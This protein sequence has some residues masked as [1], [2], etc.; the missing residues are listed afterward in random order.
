MSSQL[1]PQLFGGLRAQKILLYLSPAWFFFAYYKFINSP[2]AT[3]V[4]SL[5]NKSVMLTKQY[6]MS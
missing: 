3:L 4:A 1:S 6:F 5:V 2:V